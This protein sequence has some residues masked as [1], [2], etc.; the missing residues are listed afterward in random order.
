MNHFSKL[1]FS[2]II[3]GSHLGP[4]QE[5][6]FDISNEHHIGVADYDEQNQELIFTQSNQKPYNNKRVNLALY[7][8][9]FLNDKLVDISRLWFCDEE[10]GY[11]HPTISPDGLT[12]VFSSN[13]QSGLH[14]KLYISKRESLL[15]DWSEPELIEEL[16]ADT[17]LVFP[18]MINDSLLV[19]SA[20]YDDGKGGLDI[21]KSKRINGVWGFPENWVEL[22]SEKDDFSVEMMDEKS[23]YFTSGRNA[24]TDKIY[25]FEIIQE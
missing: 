25:Y 2:E 13:M 11:T 17:N 18:K 12:L 10:F 20:K 19:Y 24:E 14:Y 3:D 21:Y 5:V 23:G 15:D 1:Y 9:Y 7:S 4:L 8:G 6:Q 22:N 16:D